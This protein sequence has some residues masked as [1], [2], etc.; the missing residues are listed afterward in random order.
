M[1]NVQ[2]GG[3][4]Y[5]PATPTHR[6]NTLVTRAVLATSNVS[7]FKKN[8][9]QPGINHYLPIWTIGIWAGSTACEEIRSINN[10]YSYSR[11]SPMIAMDLGAWRGSI[12]LS[13]FRRTVDAA[14]IVLMRLG[15]RGYVLVSSQITPRKYLL[16]MI[17][18]DIDMLIVE[19]DLEA[20]N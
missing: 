2:W 16:G 5:L 19:Y 8:I 18:L 17:C 10:L 20:I 9:E 3:V 11:L 14:P 4:K 15:E 1:Q 7:S 6:K 12:C 13:F